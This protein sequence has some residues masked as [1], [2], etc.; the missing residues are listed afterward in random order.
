MKSMFM[1]FSLLLFF[2]KTSISQ[3]ILSDSEANS[4]VNRNS[5][6]VRYVDFH[7][8]TTMKNYYNHFSNPAETESLN[9]QNE[10]YKYLNWTGRDKAIDKKFNNFKSYRQADWGILNSSGASIL[11]TSF[12]PIEKRLTSK[13]SVVLIFSMRFFNK[14]FVTKLSGKRLKTLNSPDNSSFD[15]FK[16]E[17]NFLISQS[18]TNQNNS[19]RF[20]KPVKDKAELIDNFK[21]GK[22]SLVMTLEGA[23]IFHGKYISS[24]KEYNRTKFNDRAQ[25]EVFDN[26][27]YVKNLPYRIFFITPAHFCWN[28]ITGFAKS[29]DMDDWKRGLLTKLSRERPFRE[30][31]F[32]KGSD[33]LMGNVYRDL[34]KKDIPLDTGSSCNCHRKVIATTDFGRAVI[35]RLLEPSG[36]H[37]VPIYIDVKHMDILARLQYYRI[38]D[39]LRQNFNIKIPII[40][41]HIAMNGK[42]TALT[43][44]TGL[45][46]V[47]DVYEEV[48]DPD[49]FYSSQVKAGCIKGLNV[50]TNTINW[51]YPWSINFS[52]EEIKIIYDSDGIIGITLEERVLGKNRPNYS[53][54]HIDSIKAFLNLNGIVDSN[55]I[56]TFI[57][58]QPLFRNMFYMAEKSKRN[59]KTAWDHLSIGSDFDGIIKPV[60]YCPTAAHIPNLWKLLCDFIPLFA[61]FAEKENLLYGQSSKEIADKVIFKNGE[62][63]ILKYF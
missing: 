17:Y 28:G 39:S 20:I 45:C 4:I 2:S 54:R 51:F 41:S 42:D 56:D 18:P 10:K 60:E 55:K 15:E 37:K 9:L 26:I 52:N 32:K 13:T 12:T 8:H 36:I 48:K 7:I 11:C 43:K 3:S 16:G 44:Y 14:N 24:T 27:T 21:N 40:A 29:L 33:G 19:G 25:K 58:M 47:F 61:K 63:F 34:T 38:V 57:K 62:R 31:I 59:D 5:E 6:P 1:V 22:T 49:F 50:D 53:P 46:P 23:H 35:E 30:K